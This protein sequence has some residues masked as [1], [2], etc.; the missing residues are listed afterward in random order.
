[1]SRGHIPGPPVWLL[2]QSSGEVQLTADWASSPQTLF[3]L[4]VTNYKI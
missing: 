4:D 3:Y 2:L 1:M